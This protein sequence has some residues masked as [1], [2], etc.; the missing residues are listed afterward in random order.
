MHDASSNPEAK[1]PSISLSLS[2]GF[3]VCGVDV[4]FVNESFFDPVDLEEHI[5]DKLPSGGGNV[6]KQVN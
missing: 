2:S 5:I 1:S 6:P 3:S 4:E